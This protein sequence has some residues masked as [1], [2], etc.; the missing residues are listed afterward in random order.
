MF[1]HPLLSVPNS[2]TDPCHTVCFPSHPVPGLVTLSTLNWCLVTALRDYVS[3]ENME[4]LHLI[5]GVEGNKVCNNSFTGILSVLKVE[6]LNNHQIYSD[7]LRRM[8]N[9]C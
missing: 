3:Q 5:L 7:V 4:E 9:D 8:Y 6:D 2:M 1:K